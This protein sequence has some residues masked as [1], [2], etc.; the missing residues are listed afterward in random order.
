M[1]PFYEIVPPA[2][3]NILSKLLNAADIQSALKD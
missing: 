3:E 1:D 2:T